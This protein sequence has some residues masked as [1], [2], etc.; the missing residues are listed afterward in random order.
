MRR[1]LFFA[2]AL[3][4]HFVGQSGAP[5]L[6]QRAANPW[7]VPPGDPLE[8]KAAGFAKMLCSAVLLPVAT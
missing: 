2:S 7:E 1:S 8:H 3:V 5:G 4:C 6:R